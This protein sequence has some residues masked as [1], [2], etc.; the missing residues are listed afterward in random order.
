VSQAACQSVEIILCLAAQD[1]IVPPGG[2]TLPNLSSLLLDSIESRLNLSCPSFVNLAEMQS[3]T[4][5]DP[6]GKRFQLITPSR[7][8]VL[9]AEVGSLFCRVLFSQA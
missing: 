6:E 3:I 4:T 9:L 5:T 1:I 8:W 7:T 2:M